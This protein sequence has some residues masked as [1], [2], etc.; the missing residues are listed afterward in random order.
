M[1]DVLHLIIGALKASWGVFL[2]SVAFLLVIMILGALAL[3]YSLEDFMKDE[4]NTP[5][6]RMAVF[7][8][9]GNFPR[10]LVTMF[11]LTLGNFFPPIE[12]L[13]DEVSEWYAIWFILYICLV[14]FA[15]CQV[16]RSVFIS[17]TLKS[18]SS[19]DDLMIMEKERQ[20]KKHA[21]DMDRFF[22][23]ADDSGDG[24]LSFDE[25]EAMVKNPRVK[26]WLAAM[27]FN[28]ENVKLVFDLL[29][30]GD[31]KLTADEV[32][33]G[34]AKLKGTARSLDMI[35]LHRR[36]D[37]VDIACNQMLSCLGQPE[38][39]G[40]LMGRKSVTLRSSA[41]SAVSAVPVTNE[42]S[43]MQSGSSGVKSRPRMTFRR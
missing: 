21:C 6:A 31:N 1:F 8:R 18:V 32:V 19:D 42:R 2:W 5:Q 9:F 20:M 4:T 41:V 16:I 15:M 24:F 43:S 40:G 30:D 13:R 10:A 35:A 12:I 29:D 33:H 25:F 14:N 26:S 38:T 17:E 7:S 23:E 11:E 27:D 22:R 39:N 36:L 3:N 28:I 34:V 37:Y